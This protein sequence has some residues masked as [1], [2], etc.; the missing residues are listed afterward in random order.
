MG[1]VLAMTKTS[2]FLSLPAFAALC[3]LQACSSSGAP[4]DT[5]FLGYYDSV[6]ALVKNWNAPPPADPL[7]FLKPSDLTAVENKTILIKHVQA[8]VYGAA[9]IVSGNTRVE[10]FRS[11]D[12]VGLSLDRGVLVATRGFGPDL[13]VAGS[14]PFHSALSKESSQDYQR[15][16]RHLDGENHTN[17]TVFACSIAFEGAEPLKFVGKSYSTRRYKESCLGTEYEIENVYWVNVRNGDVVKSLQ[18]ASEGIGILRIHLL[19]D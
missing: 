7:T 17:R 19:V 11:G 6:R 14:D 9:E 16:F 3:F 4:E 10:T 13:L 1:Q 2:K 5:L 12:G 15:V 8:G 18:W